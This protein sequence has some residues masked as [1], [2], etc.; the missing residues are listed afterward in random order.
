[1]KNLIK[2]Y[3]LDKKIQVKVEDAVTFDT[4]IRFDRVLI[5]AECTHEGSI[6]H[7][8][9]FLPENKEQKNLKKN[10]VKANKNIS[11]QQ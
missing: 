7:I 1:M 2:K 4:E 3:K 6:K 10:E 11:R 9:K 5:D 8:K